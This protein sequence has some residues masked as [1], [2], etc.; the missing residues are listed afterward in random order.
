MNVQLQNF[1]TYNQ[2]QRYSPKT[3]NINLIN[4]S[5]VVSFGDKFESS[6]SKDKKQTQEKGSFA[7]ALEK[8]SLSFF[9]WSEKISGKTNTET[10]NQQ[11]DQAKIIRDLTLKLN[12]ANGK[13]DKLE[14]K[15]S[16]DKEKINSQNNEI[17]ELNHRIANYQKENIDLK[18][19]VNASQRKLQ[20]TIE[21]HEK[22]EINS[23]IR[24]EILNEANK[25][26]DYDILNP[27]CADCIPMYKPSQYK[28]NYADIKVGT[29]N[30]ANMKPLNIPEIK[31]N[32]TFDFE[33]P[34]GEMKIKKADLKEFNEPFEIQSNISEKYTD[35]LVWNDDKVARDL[36]QNFFD[37]HGQT[38]DGV[39]F[40]FEPSGERRLFGPRK[41]KVRI[42]GKST[43]NFKEAI[44]LGES[45]SHGNKNAAGNYGEGLKMVTLKLL[46]QNKASDVKI[47]SGNWEVTCSL[48][49]DE[50]LDSKLI[51]YK[52]EPVEYYDG[53]YIEFEIADSDLHD[54]L[55]ES[56]NRFYHSS[57][58]HFKCPD[59]END[60]FGFKIL[61]N[62]E[63]GGLYIAGQ[64]FEI[65]EK[66]NGIEN[67]AVFIKEKIPTN[68]FDV[69]RDRTSISGYDL[70]KIYRWLAQKST[71]EEQKQ[72]IKATEKFACGDKKGL[73]ILNE[74]FIEK[75]ADHISDHKDGA[76]K[77][78]DNYIAKP[79]LFF[80]FDMLSDLR[81]N[82][83]KIFP[84]DYEKLGMKSLGSV[85]NLS[86]NHTP[87][88]PTQND[89][90][91]INILKRALNDLT[92]LKKEHFSPEE[93]DAKIYLFDA[94]SKKENSIQRYENAL[95]EAI[96][97]DDKSKGFWLDKTYLKKASFAKVLET[98]LHE[99]SHKAGGDGDSD[100]SYK[101]TR[102]NKVA[103][104][105]II[106]N[107]KIAQK[108]RIYS[109]IWNSL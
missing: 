109:D 96:I 18:L 49:D 98:A 5:N 31:S 65:N 95:A 45:S 90:V 60:L 50:R 6:K 102:V 94:N 29:T 2:Y 70:S 9:N 54:H 86:R 84:N 28:E 47:G 22:G 80:N 40:K 107:P 82:G 51:N 3:S 23:A 19:E 38:L 87:I 57:N 41:T 33:L 68:V 44:L 104:E 1:Q 48:K 75:L 12:Q 105:Q 55:R 37:G 103:L 4:F 85:I 53:N 92:L 13:I 67:A 100:F 66:Y 63:K 91:K 78:P 59:F 14:Q 39:H 62:G 32:G 24:E 20:Q 88:V 35:S 81:H 16:S 106:N 17:A 71:V 42:E 58:P 46:T 108:F 11:F 93:L 72:V 34:K 64:R 79:S 43:Y 15:R 30:R 97:E 26:L 25:E 7:K 21:A 76:I 101:L 27:S 73:E 99:L 89:K 8:I 52:V 61:P 83:Y 74:K 10:N 77:F 36:L 56:I 69:S